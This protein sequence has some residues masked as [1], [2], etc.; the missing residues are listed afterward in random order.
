MYKSVAVTV[1][2]FVTYAVTGDGTLRMRREV[3]P[4]ATAMLFDVPN[5][6]DT[7]VSITE[8]VCAPDVFGVTEKVPVPLDNVASGGRTANSSVLVK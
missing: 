1:R 7:A 4:G 2:L 8:T 6:V 5:S 3:V